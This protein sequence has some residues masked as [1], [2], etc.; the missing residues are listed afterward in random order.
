[1]RGIRLPRLTEEIACRRPGSAHACG[2][3]NGACQDGGRLE[4]KL[5]LR[6]GNVRL[7]CLTLHPLPEAFE[8]DLPQHE[9]PKVPLGV[10]V[11]R[12][13]FS[14]AVVGTF[15]GW[16]IEVVAPRIE[17]QLVEQVGIKTGIGQNRG[18]G[19]LEN[20]E[21]FGHQPF[22]PAPRDSGPTQKKRYGPHSLMLVRF[23]ALPGSRGLATGR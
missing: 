14:K 11:V 7:A 15:I 10:D 4:Q 1:M 2:H 21:C 19:G 9:A 17:G 5:V 3:E 18:I 22:I 13:P 6:G 8:S 23:A 20:V 16:V 12:V